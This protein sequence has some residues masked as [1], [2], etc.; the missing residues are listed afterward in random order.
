[1]T[2]SSPQPRVVYFGDERTAEVDAPGQS[3]LKT[4][5]RARVPH[6]AECG[7]HGRCTT[8]R[9]RILDGLANVS[10]RTDA[11]RAIAEARGWDPFTR[12]AC[13]T[14][15][16][17]EVTV[18]RIVRSAADAARIRAEEA[19][20]QRGRELTLAILFCDLRNFT[21]LTERHLPHDTRSLDS[22]R[23]IA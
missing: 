23:K 10:P 12:L 15:V 16:H 17:G 5:Q 2:T 3:I 9:V 21:S 1:V 18:E 13:Q 19:N 4:S 8:C 11:E 22:S 7:G 14:R 6:I 20:T